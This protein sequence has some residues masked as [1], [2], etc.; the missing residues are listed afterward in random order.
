MP[1]SFSTYKDA[2]IQLQE[3][4]TS[5]GYTVQIQPITGTD[6]YYSDGAAA[7]SHGKILFKHGT[8]EF[9]VFFPDMYCYVG[10]SAPLNEAIKAWLADIKE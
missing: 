8:S 10:V 6:M 9:V 2:E 5:L 3:R 7:M 4:V 1:P